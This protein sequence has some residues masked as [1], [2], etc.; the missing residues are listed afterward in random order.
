ME[1]LEELYERQ[2]NILKNRKIIDKL[3]DKGKQLKEKLDQVKKELELRQDIK[4][5]EQN[6]NMLTINNESTDVLKEKHVQYIC[7][8]EKSPKKERY[9]PFSTLVKEKEHREKTTKP[10]QL[11]PLAESITLLAEQANK[12]PVSNHILQYTHSKC[13]FVP[14]F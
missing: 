8:I 5:L 13:I 7:S 1:A 2:N 14:Y 11:I 9:K 6:M 3:P 10:T 12:L 4:E